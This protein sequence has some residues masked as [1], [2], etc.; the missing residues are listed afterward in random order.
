VRNESHRFATR[1]NRRKRARRVSLT[2]LEGI[3]GIG[4][5]RS[6]RLITVFGSLEAIMGS[7]VDD[8]QKK[9]GLPRETAATLLA[10]LAERYSTPAGEEGGRAGPS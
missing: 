10:R 5:A 2:L 4:Q 6:K 9:A 7:S 3:E 1:I 8:L